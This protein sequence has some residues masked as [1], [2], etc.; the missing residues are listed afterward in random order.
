MSSLKLTFLNLKNQVY[1]QKNCLF[2]LHGIF[3]AGW[4][5]KTGGY[6][7][8]YNSLCYET[9]NGGMETRPCRSDKIDFVTVYAVCCLSVTEAETK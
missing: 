3:T 9:K 7:E 1:F 2:Y 4:T 5:C 6:M 8:Y